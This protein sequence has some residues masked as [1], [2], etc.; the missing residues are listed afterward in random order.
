[1]DRDQQTSGWKWFVEHEAYTLALITLAAYLV[2]TGSNV[3]YLGALG[4][5]SG[6]LISLP[7][8][9]WAL[10]QFGLLA[11][12][13][14]LMIQLFIWRMKLYD[15]QEWIGGKT[16]IIAFAVIGV[17]VIGQPSMLRGWG[18][19]PSWVKVMTLL[20]LLALLARFFVVVNKRRFAP[21]TY[22]LLMLTFW[23]FGASFGH[24]AATTQTSWRVVEVEGDDT[25]YVVLNV[26]GDQLIVAPLTDPEHGMYERRFIHLDPTSEGVSESVQAIGPITAKD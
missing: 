3:A 13:L 19:G 5:P 11:V 2:F 15:W 23:F 25:N 8:Y 24:E 17:F 21:L 18:L 26:R 4:V 20:F 14:F 10:P 16:A 6:G 9:V 22:V 1:M 7:S 12:C